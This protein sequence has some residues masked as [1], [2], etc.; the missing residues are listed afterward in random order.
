MK[1]LLRLDAKRKVF[2]GLAV[3][4]LLFGLLLRQIRLES[5]PVFADESIYLRWAQIMR[6]EPT[7]R[8]LPLS[9]GKQPLYMWAVIPVFKVITDPLVAGRTL[10]AVA[11]IFTAIGI[12][13]ASF[14]LFKK[15]RL[16]LMASFLWIILPYSLYFDRMA[17][18]DGF[19]A[20]FGIWT[21]VF[22]LLSLRYFRLD[23]AMIAGFCLGFAWLTKSPAIFI[24]VLLP[25]LIILQDRPFSSLF[26]V[27]KS[28]G[29]LVVTWII[30]FSMYNILR[31]GPEF[32][33]IALRNADYVFPLSEVLRHPLFPL[34]PHLKDIFGF[35]LNLM[36]PVGLALALFGIV[37]GRFTNF[38]PRLL[39]IIWWMLPLFAQAA[40]AK[41]VT[42]RYFLYTLPFAVMFA[43]LAL[44]QIAS[45]SKKIFLPVLST[46]IILCLVY[47]YLLIFSP[48]KAP[49]PRIER[50]G[51]LEEWTAGFGLKEVSAYLK[52]EAAKGPVLVGSEGFF[53]TPYDGLGM[54]LNKV[55]N[56]RVIGVGVWID[57]V[58]EK[59][60]NS[61][62]DN[63]VFLVV[64]ST[65]FHGDAE[66]LG[67]RLIK[68]YP[69]EARPDSTRESLLFFE[70]PVSLS[71]SR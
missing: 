25:T 38:R 2:A 55:P 61:L 47:D 43:G 42:A 12:G 62:S 8:F 15:I 5:I 56:I 65:R 57:S 19:L 1:N 28:V 45:R 21:F 67:L 18:V 34:I 39:L 9:D 63:K 16:S 6:A 41:T 23:M 30:A 60:I 54:Y 10:S 37:A 20:M 24:A 49:L 44:E 33:M 36:T 40:V 13:L 22:S 27:A 53:G 29:L 31:L 68:S 26:R 4:I 46:L 52:N 59:L 17:L 50:S 32:H 58:N 3:L 35:F 51:Y 7:L 11:G 70:V 71:K 66:K 64:N 69:K 48:Q 14:L